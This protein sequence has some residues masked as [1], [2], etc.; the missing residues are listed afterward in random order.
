MRKFVVAFVIMVGVY[1][2]LI[3]KSEV[4]SIGETLRQADWRFLILA[5]GLEIIWMCNMALE[6]WAIYRGMGIEEKYKRLL[7]LTTAAN[8][9]NIIM[10]SGG[11]GGS[12][13]LISEAKRQGVSTARVTVAL[14]VY[15]FLEYLSFLGVLALALLAL[16]R[17]STL[18]SV[19][20]TA[21]AIMVAIAGVIGTILY[22]GMR[23]PEAF[24]KFL[25]F[26]AR[27]INRILK[28][29]LHRD[30][31]SE[32]HAHEFAHDAAGGLS[33]LRHQP[34][35]LV[36]PGL[37]VLNSKILMLLIFSLIFV[38]FNVPYT[39]GTIIAGYAISY[40]FS[41]VSITPAGMGFVEAFL[42]LTLTQMW[43]PL[44]AATLITLGYR[45]VTFWFPLFIGML[46]FRWATG[47][48]KVQAIT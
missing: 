19:E 44:S 37:L 24:G 40:L 28:V 11:V 46:V 4:Y 8:F 23:S 42:P 10:P 6:I 29:F 32:A 31:I 25:A 33:R 12:T 7:V 26:W 38:A 39:P 22:F 15:I 1:F 27:I 3:R 47:G 9:V 18:T 20:L 5:V 36:L 41:I 35:G 48:Q 13:L 2:V 16:F 45:G 17:R 34:K 43:V 30:Y 21:S 14:A